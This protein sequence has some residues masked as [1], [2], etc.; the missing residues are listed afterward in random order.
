MLLAR[1]RRGALLVLVATLPWCL[2]SAGLLPGHA[3]SRVPVASAASW[4]GETR[5][6][7]PATLLPRRP[8]TLVP[9]PQLSPTFPHDTGAIAT[10]AVGQDTGVSWSFDYGAAGWNT[11]EMWPVDVDLVAVT[12][13]SAGQETL[14]SKASGATR[15]YQEPGNAGS[16]GGTENLSLGFDWPAAA[17]AAAG[18]GPYYAVCLHQEAPTPTPDVYSYTGGTL[19]QTNTTVYKVLNDVAPRITLS[20]SAA[21]DGQTV[22]VSGT[23]WKY[24]YYADLSNGGTNVLLVQYP[25]ANAYRYLDAVTPTV[26]LNTGNFTVTLHLTEAPGTYFVCVGNNWFHR[27]HPTLG[28]GLKLQ[29]L[30]GAPPSG[31]GGGTS[32][33]ATAL[34]AAVRHRARGP[35]PLQ[36][37]R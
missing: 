30:A 27:Y 26:D 31:S 17:T 20:T 2:V 1:A 34:Y 14:C 33:S 37:V 22:T 3:V 16:T 13:V 28:Q 5:Q 9:P 25:Y 23:N 11:T 12:H 6:I 10:T 18:G 32:P 4:A 19:D 21:Y 35:R 15:V 8:L 7:P 24:Y 36:H 29:I